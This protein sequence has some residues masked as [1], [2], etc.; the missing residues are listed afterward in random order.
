MYLDRA[1]M[2][3]KTKGIS[4]KKVGESCYVIYEVGR[5]YDPEK[6][7]TVPERVQIGLRIPAQPDMM[8][9]NENYLQ[10][11]SPEMEKM[12]EKE[13]ELT[14][15]YEEKR[16]RQN[17]LRELFLSMYHEMMTLSKKLPGEIVNEEKVIRLNKVLEPLHEML[18]QEEYAELLEMIPAPREEKDRKKGLTYS[19]VAILLNHY[20][21]LMNRYFRKRF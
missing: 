17:I 18:Q 3:P 4:Y 21:N 15:E 19:D 12:E 8:L 1:V 11:F 14:G 2:I 13:T 5:K 9:P 20:K 16:Q 10:Y 6:Q 7:Y